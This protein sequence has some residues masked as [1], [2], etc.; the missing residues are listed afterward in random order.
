MTVMNGFT[1]VGGDGAYLC[2]VIGKE[3]FEYAPGGETSLFTPSDLGG[4]TYEDE[5]W[6]EDDEDNDDVF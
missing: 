1:Y 3:V 5:D 4:W 2:L 6:D